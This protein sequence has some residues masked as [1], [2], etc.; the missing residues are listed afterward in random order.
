MDHAEKYVK[1][2]DEEKEIIIQA[3]ISF[4]ISGEQPWTKKDNDQFDVT[5]ASFDGAEIAELVG[6]YLLSLLTNLGINVGLYRDD[7][8]AICLLTAQDAENVKKEICRIFGEQNLRITAK[9]E[10]RFP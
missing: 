10:C 6:L 3:R 1:I 4:L 2:S 7:G 9:E 5:M 8:L